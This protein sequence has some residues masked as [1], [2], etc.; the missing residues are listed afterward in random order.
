MYPT[1]K[2]FSQ[3]QHLTPKRA[4][5]LSLGNDWPPK[6][7]IRYLPQEGQVKVNQ[8]MVTSV[9]SLWTNVKYIEWAEP[10]GRIKH[11]DGSER[12]G[13]YGA[14]DTLVGY[15]PREGGC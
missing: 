6:C 2:T 14:E 10:G 4:L 1:P 3:K 13:T 9:D 15:A 11:F 7:T 5:V 8:L 12:D